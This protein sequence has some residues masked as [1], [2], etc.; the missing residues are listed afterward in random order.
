WS[1]EFEGGT[2]STSTM[3]NPVVEYLSAGVF[4]VTLTASNGAGSN[5]TT[6]T[7]YIAVNEG[8]TADF[9]SSA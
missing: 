2:P 3:Q 1:W 8:P 9:T 4:G 5:T 6:Q 7:S